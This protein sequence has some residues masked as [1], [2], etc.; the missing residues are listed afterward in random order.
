M[1]LNAAY[2]HIYKKTKNRKRKKKNYE[3]IAL[4]K[5]VFSIFQNST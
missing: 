2:I 4:L 3:N 1:Q 5:Q